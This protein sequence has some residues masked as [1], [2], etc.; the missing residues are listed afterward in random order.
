MTEASNPGVNGTW[1]CSWG[2]RGTE[3]CAGPAVVHGGLCERHRKVV[4]LVEAEDQIRADW[5]RK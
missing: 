3:P 4:A 1:P 5:E 2:W